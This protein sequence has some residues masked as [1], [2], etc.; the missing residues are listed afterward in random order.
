[1]RINEIRSTNRIVHREYWPPAGRAREAIIMIGGHAHKFIWLT[2]LRFTSN[3]LYEYVYYKYKCNPIFVLAR[4]SQP[5]RP[6][7]KANSKQSE[8]IP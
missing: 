7:E 1:M 2:C 4:H 6:N 3:L 5:V 8:F